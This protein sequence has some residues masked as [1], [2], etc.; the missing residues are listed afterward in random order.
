MLFLIPENK[1]RV[2]IILAKYYVYRFLDA[3]G[4]IIYIGKTNNIEKRM[5]N[6]HFSSSGHLTRECYVGTDSIGYAELKSDNAMRIYEIYLISKHKPLYN[7]EFNYR[8]EGMDIELP[9][10]IWIEYPIT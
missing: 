6:Q 4:N 5:S 7:Q 9:E 3:D 10:P 8:D 1:Q 2:V